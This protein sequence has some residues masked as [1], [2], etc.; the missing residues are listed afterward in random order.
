MELVPGF[1]IR[2]GPIFTDFSVCGDFEDEMALAEGLNLNTGM[3]GSKRWVSSVLTPL[4][5]VGFSICGDFEG[6]LA[7]AE[8]LGLNSEIGEGN[9]GLNR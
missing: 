3:R 2:E 8:G 4:P 9:S 7:L 5:C 1:L 6:E